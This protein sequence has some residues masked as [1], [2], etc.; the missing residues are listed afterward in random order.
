MVNPKRVQ[1]GKAQ[2]QPR[3]RT[4]VGPGDLQIALERIR[5]VL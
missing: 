3:E 1:N 2:R 5:Q 4:Y